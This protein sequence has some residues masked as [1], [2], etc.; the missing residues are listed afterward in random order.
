MPF[1]V[2][3]IRT[4]M[5]AATH[6]P[7]CPDGTVEPVNNVGP[8]CDTCG[9]EDP[10]RTLADAPSLLGKPARSSYISPDE[11]KRIVYP[12]IRRYLAGLTTSRHGRLTRVRAIN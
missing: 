5:T 11:H 4:G 2:R 12:S 9:T 3:D 8:V 6:C 7:A 10:G 1:D